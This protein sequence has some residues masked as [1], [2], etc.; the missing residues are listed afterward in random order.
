MKAGIS[1]LQ[2]LTLSNIKG[3]GPKAIL[4]V[5][6]YL[7]DCNRTIDDY[8]D[9]VTVLD[10]LKIKKKNEDGKGTSLITSYDLKEAE[11]IALRILSASEKEGI[12]VI[13]Y[14]EESFPDILKN[15]ID[16]DGKPAPPLLLF[17]KGDISIIDIPCIAVIG[18]REITPNGEKA[19]MY[20]SR[21]FAAENG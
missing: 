8:S 6:N 14:Y 2:I 5:G 10:K 11:S 9:F 12:G 4:K 13:S 20:I 15:T 21:E 18:S 1:T 3:V 19:G 7:F 17:Y 16:E